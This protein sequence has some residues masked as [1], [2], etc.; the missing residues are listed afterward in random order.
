MRLPGAAD[1]ASTLRSG[2]L[3]WQTGQGQ[4]LRNLSELSEARLVTHPVSTVYSGLNRA[5]EDARNCSSNPHFTDPSD[6]DTTL[7]GTHCNT[8]VTN[9]NFGDMRCHGD[10]NGSSV[11]SEGTEVLP[12][13]QSVS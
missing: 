6:T 13:L 4:R 8:C 3:C 2:G 7:G 9:C 12:A 10:R 5:W 1:E 11:R